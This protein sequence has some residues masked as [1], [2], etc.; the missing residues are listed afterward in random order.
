MP[1]SGLD[2]DVT[3]ARDGT[4][5][6]IQPQQAAADRSGRGSEDVQRRVALHVDARRSLEL[7]RQRT[8]DVDPVE[9]MW[10]IAFGPRRSMPPSATSIEYWPFGLWK[11]PVNVPFCPFCPSCPFCPFA[12]LQT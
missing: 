3:L 11:W 12:P 1:L 6:T 7:E 10:T 8:V 9:L 4:A 2:H 5:A